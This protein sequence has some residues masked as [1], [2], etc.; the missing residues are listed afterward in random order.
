MWSDRYCYYSIQYDEQFSQKIDKSFVIDCLLKLKLF[1]KSN[2]Q[3]FI[4]SNDF[5]WVEIYLVETQNGNF[6]TSDQEYK[7]VNLI[8]I[9]CSKGP[10]VNQYIYIDVFKKIANQLNWKLYLRED[11]E[12]NEN[13]EL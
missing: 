6:T 11:D 12:G 9:V 10:N 7:F 8:E 3:L 2:H 4:N 5:P 13:V 1:K